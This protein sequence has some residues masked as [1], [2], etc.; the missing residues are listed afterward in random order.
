MRGAWFLCLLFSVGCQDADPTPNVIIVS[1]DT[2]RADA[3]GG[4]GYA[5][6]TSPNIDGFLSE[7]IVFTQAHVPEPHTLPSHT[8][9]FTSLHPLSHGVEA[10]FSGGR[11][12]P[13]H[14]PTLASI[15]EERGRATA[16]FINGGFLHPRF[17]I[18]RG[19]QRYDYMSDVGTREGSESSRYGRNAAETN[20]AVFDWLDEN[21]KLPFFL[22]VHYFDIHSDWELLP[23]DSPERYR[24][25]FLKGEAAEASWS[26]SASATDYLMAVDRGELTMTPA[27]LERVRALYDAGLRYTDDRLGEFFDGLKAR[28]LY[29]NAIIVLVSDHGEEFLEHGMTQ[30]TQ[31]Y[32]ELLHVPIAFRFPASAQL[33]HRAWKNMVLN[34]DVMPTV[35]DYLGVEPPETL[36]GQSLLPMIR[37][38]GQRAVEPVVFVSTTT[39]KLGLY[40]RGWKLIYDP[41]RKS[42]ELYDLKNDPREREDRASREPAR[43]TSA[44]KKLERWRA[45]LPKPWKDGEQTRV[46]LDPETIKQLQSLGYAH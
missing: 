9:L 11:A 34:V 46:E 35:L 45:A 44:L 41:A 43:V 3:L 23:Y 21:G 6:D 33:P 31:L 5:R 37:D 15:L 36:Q 42:A 14:I 25:M 29:D 38:Q 13:A 30:H 16:A 28:G 24:Q 7:S 40:D 12:L 4:F 27:L 39:K 10:R 19:F 17:G 1:L 18:G 26:E 8:S 2:L 32:E 20:K 22:F